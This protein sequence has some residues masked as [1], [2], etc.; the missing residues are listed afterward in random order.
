[1]KI[2]SNIISTSQYT[3]GK[4]F[5]YVSSY[6]EYIGYYYILNDRYF[7]GKEYNITSLE[8]I[9]INLQN[10]N[11]LL[12]QSP[13]YIYGLL[14]GVN[15]IKNNVKASNLITTNKDYEQGF[16][17]RYFVKQLNVTPI[18]IKEVNKE[19]FEKLQTDPFYQTIQI[20]DYFTFT[21]EELNLLDKR[22]PGLKVFLS[23]DPLITSTEEDGR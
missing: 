13:T 6:K 8:L 20:K 23:T 11:I 7:T 22:M 12:T 9:K 2:P 15:I 16:R 18:L 3:S 10:T 17:I 4:E 14:S 1:M 19:T 21:E 5:M